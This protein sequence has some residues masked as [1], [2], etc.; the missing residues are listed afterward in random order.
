MAGGSSVALLRDIE[1]LF[2]A[3][4]A[5]GLSDRELLEKLSQQTGGRYWKPSELSHLPGDISYSEAGIS[6][7]ETRDLWDAPVF[8]LAALLI[9]ALVGRGPA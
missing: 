6:I 2:D 9:R 5:S 1:M 3:G 4:T 7:R 8:F